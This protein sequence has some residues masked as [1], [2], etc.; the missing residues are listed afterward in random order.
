[1]LPPAFGGSGASAEV[2]RRMAQQYCKKKRPHFCE[3]S[4]QQN[5]LFGQHSGEID[6]VMSFTTAPEVTYEGIITIKKSHTVRI[7]MPVYRE[8][9]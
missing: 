1:M 5:S 8:P 6:Y 4:S 2:A 9:D 3:Y 7:N